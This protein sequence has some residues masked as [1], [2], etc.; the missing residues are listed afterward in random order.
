[1]NVKNIRKAVEFLEWPDWY[2]STMIHMNHFNKSKRLPILFYFSFI[3]TFGTVE[4]V[5]KLLSHPDE[6][7]NWDEDMVE[8]SLEAWSDLSD[9]IMRG[10]DGVQADFIDEES[11]S[12]YGID[13]ASYLVNK[14]LNGKRIKPD[15]EVID[16]NNKN[17]YLL[18]KT[19]TVVPALVG[20]LIDEMDK[21]ETNKPS[22]PK[23]VEPT[24][25]WKDQ[26]VAEI[27]EYYSNAKNIQSTKSTLQE[28]V[29]SILDG[30]TSELFSIRSQR[31]SPRKSS[32]SAGI[33]EKQSFIIKTPN[34][35]D[36]VGHFIIFE[37]NM[38][39]N[40][41]STNDAY[42]EASKLKGSK[43]FE[44]KE[45]FKYFYEMIF[46]DNQYIKVG[47]ST[48]SK[49]NGSE[50]PKIIE[51]KSDLIIPVEDVDNV[52]ITKPVLPVYYSNAQKSEIEKAM[53]VAK[54]LNT[55]DTRQRVQKTQIEAQRF[56][57]ASR[58]NVN[59]NLLAASK[60]NGPKEAK[61]EQ[62]RKRRANSKE[63]EMDVPEEHRS[64]TTNDYDNEYNAFEENDD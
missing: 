20:A 63:F 52:V 6:E 26:L 44:A 1:M 49:S 37:R 61:P 53:Q 27:K 19:R 60:S 42:R 4:D 3:D 18:K 11:K 29:K 54:N 14:V 10:E 45:T 30:N 25:G 9:G 7:F 24:G 36:R 32:G 28:Y 57:N 12:G 35:K 41:K 34:S 33:F 16:K 5:K 64:Y 56:I 59:N 21:L 51:D 2:T 23:M 46:G 40:E 8:A 17:I 62:A 38:S 43:Q 58:P 22:E 50:K 15:Q 39:I 13:T 48:I 31:Q 55:E 47:D